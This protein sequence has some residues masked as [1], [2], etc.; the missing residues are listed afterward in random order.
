MTEQALDTYLKE[1][2]AA[3]PGKASI[4]A[5]EVESGRV[6]WALEPDTQVVSAST[7]KVPVLLSALEEVRQGRL[8]LGQTLDLPAEV[9]LED[10]KVFEYGPTSRSLWE[11]LYWMIVESD[12]TATNTV[13]DALG[14]DAINSYAQEVLGLK[15][16]LCRRKML[17]WAAI[18]AGRN[19]YTS[20]A[21]QG[22]MYSLLFHGRILDEALRET[23]LDMLRRQRSTDLFLRY[24]PEN[25]TVAHKTGGLDYV[26]HDAGIF[27]VPR[28]PFYLGIFTWDGPS[29]EGDKGQKMFLG[30]LTKAIY[31]TYKG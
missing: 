15:D 26:C 4:L 7:I 25:V 10:S 3:F 8:S 2:I 28:R 16:T 27:Y 29:P 23:A 20:A 13:I 18:E 11:L 21:D 1:E 17:D 9:L 19:N 22:R 30:R 5:A 6:L 12:N 31:D 14:Y 24:I